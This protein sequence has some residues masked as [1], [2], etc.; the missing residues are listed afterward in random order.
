M[1]TSLEFQPLCGE[2][3]TRYMYLIYRWKANGYTVSTCTYSSDGNECANGGKLI[4]SRVHDTYIIYITAKAT[5]FLVFHRLYNVVAYIIHI[6]PT[7]RWC[8]VYGVDTHTIHTS[9]EWWTRCIRP[10]SSKQRN[11]LKLYINT[12]ISIH[13]YT[14]YTSFLYFLIK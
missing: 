4:F 7:T 11:G 8:I 3:S 6:I 13:M 9:V 10:N 14:I 12:R 1:A 2:I 5:F